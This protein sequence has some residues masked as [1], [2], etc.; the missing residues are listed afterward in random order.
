MITLLFL[1]K[2]ITRAKGDILFQ[3]L[4]FTSCVKIKNQQYELFVA[5]DIFSQDLKGGHNNSSF[6]IFL[7]KIVTFINFL[8]E[9]FR[10]TCA[11]IK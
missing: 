4:D 11:K 10:L 9:D 7:Y 1:L 2:S 3:S 8:L 6:F 5:K